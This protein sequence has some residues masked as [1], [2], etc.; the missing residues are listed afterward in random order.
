MKYLVAIL[1]FLFLSASAY[2]QTREYKDL[3]ILYADGT[4]DSY[5]KLV[6][7][8]EK[9][10]LKDATKKDPKPYFWMAKGLYKISVSGTD[11]EN[12]KN[13]YKD[14]IKFLGKGIK[15]DYKYNDGSYTSEESEFVDMLQMTLFETANNE[16]SDGS[17]K[18]AFSWV[19]KYTKITQNKVG[20]N[21][22]M[23]AC[24]YE[25][26]DKTTAR[27]YWKKAETE[28]ETI[29][30]IENWSEADKFMLKYGVLHSAGA[31]KRSRQEDKAKALVNKVAQWFE[32]DEDWEALYDE[33][34]N[35]PKE[36]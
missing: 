21:Y 10:T 1:S 26:A 23:G 8:A 18:R 9:Y 12:Y 16:I 4:Y 13:A 25:A 30:S 6:K 22:L 5:K 7:Q 24:K 31:L 27:D 35:R 33:I 36:K 17:Y 2:S 11:D 14:A 29:E 19:L 20:A 28:L 15:Y 3:V 32:E 34:V